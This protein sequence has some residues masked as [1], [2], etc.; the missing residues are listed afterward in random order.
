MEFFGFDLIDLIQAVGLLGIFFI[1]FAESGLF[2]GFFLPGDSLLFTAGFLASQGYLP[3]GAL[4]AGCFI[5]AV[6]GDNFGYAFGRRVGPRIFQRPQSLLFNPRNLEYARRF[7]GV[8]GGKTIVMARFLP[9]VRTFAPIL[10]GVGGMRYGVFVAYNL[11]GAFLW[12][13]LLPLVGYYLGSSVPNVDRYLF[14]I[15]LGIVVISALPSLIAVLR[16]PERRAWVVRFVQGW[17]GRHPAWRRA[18][19]IGLVV[20][21]VVALALPFFPFAWVGFIGLELLGWRVLLQEKLRAWR[22]K[23]EKVETR[24]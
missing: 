22:Q 7:Y 13:V 3:I 23:A 10:A 24:K 1:V 18:I 20:F 14:P 17:L 2:I 9:F 8:H 12:A 11:V 4:V 15:V 6:L 5:A 16:D 19:G 21:G